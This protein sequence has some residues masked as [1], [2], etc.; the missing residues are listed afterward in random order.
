MKIL[1]ITLVFSCIIM[2]YNR[3]TTTL[4]IVA[5]AAVVMLG[6]V[7]NFVGQASAATAIEDT[8]RT[9][10]EKIPRLAQSQ[11]ESGSVSRDAVGHGDAVSAIA[12]P[13]NR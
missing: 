1:N 7:A 6:L 9:Q 5:L 3:T 4:V 8:A 10:G 12:H 13:L 2:K 11:Q